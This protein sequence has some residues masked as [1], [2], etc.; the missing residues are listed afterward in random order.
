D[1]TAPTTSASLAATPVGEWY[2]ARTVTLTASDATS[3]PAL[4]LYRVDGGRWTT[5]AGPFLVASFGPHTLEHRSV[6]RAG[7]F[8]AVK[9]V[10]WGSGVWASAQLA[11]LSAFVTSLGVADLQKPL[12]DA[13]AKVT[14]N[15]NA[16]ADLDKF[17]K[18]VVDEAGSGLTFAQADQL[19]A[20]NQIE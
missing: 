19:L 15:K 9:S 17:L 20:V 8:E 13:A 1:V 11:G 6:D 3:G 2:S 14:K 18:L 16:C 4:T 7:N 10:S 5:Y 12:T